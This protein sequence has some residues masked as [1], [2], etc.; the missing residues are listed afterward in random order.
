MV[1]LSLR[2][3]L[4]LFG[5]R[6]P[7]WRVSSAPAAVCPSHAVGGWYYRPA[8]DVPR[9]IDLLNRDES[10]TQHGRVGRNA[11]KS[12]LV[13]LLDGK[14]AVLPRAGQQPVDGVQSPESDA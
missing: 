6:S 2:Q 14:I 13:L 12:A 4:R 5:L 1:I 9:V 7:F 8:A 3:L 10:H 11:K